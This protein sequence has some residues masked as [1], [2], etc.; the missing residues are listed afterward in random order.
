MINVFGYYFV[1]AGAGDSVDHVCQSCTESQSSEYLDLLDSNSHKRCGAN[2]LALGSNSSGFCYCLY[3]W[4][5]NRQWSQS[6]GT[7]MDSAFQKTK[8]LVWI[9]QWRAMA[10]YVFLNDTNTV[11]LN[12]SLILRKVMFRKHWFSVDGHLEIPDASFASRY[13]EIMTGLPGNVPLTIVSSTDNGYGDN[14][15]VWEPTGIDVSNTADVAY[16]VTVSGIT[17]TAAS[18]YT[19][20][21]K[22]FKPW[23]F[24]ENE[25]R[26]RKRCVFFDWNRSR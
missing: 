21:V 11:V 14:T 1:C 26:I 12:I 18:S 24:Q 25:R 16:T 22:I 17:G 19:Y 9:Y 20:T 2:N 6:Q 8:S 13:C 4:L 10:L 15:L 5:R 3:Q 7:K 23:F